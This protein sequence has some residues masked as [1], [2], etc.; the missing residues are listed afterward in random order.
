M[1][2]D[3]FRQ[4]ADSLKALNKLRQIQN[5]LSRERF[6]IEEDGVKVVVS[7]DLKIRE[8]QIDGQKQERA[9]KV[10]NKVFEQTQKSVARKMQEMGGGLG[11][12]LGGLK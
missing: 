12:L 11:G 9:I 7:G 6:T 1:V 2:F 8:L 10:I 3:K 5:E 4:G